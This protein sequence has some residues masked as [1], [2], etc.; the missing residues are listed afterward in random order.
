MSRTF[1]ATVALY[2]ALPTSGWARTVD[3]YDMAPPALCAETSMV[4][5]VLVSTS[6]VQQLC[7]GGVSAMIQLLLPS[8]GFRSL[9][10]VSRLLQSSCGAEASVAG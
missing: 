3:M 8:E 5:A 1:N 2:Q 9:I 6:A 7:S 4:R 10:R